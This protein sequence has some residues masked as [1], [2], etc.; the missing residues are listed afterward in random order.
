MRERLGIVSDY[1]G[2]ISPAY[3]VLKAN[4]K[5]D[6]SIFI[7]IYLDLNHTISEL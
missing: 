4:V 2:I 1:D 7:S 3:T 5:F 6:K